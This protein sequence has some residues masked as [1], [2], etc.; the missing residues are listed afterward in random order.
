MNS[1]AFKRVLWI[2][3]AASLATAGCGGDVKKAVLSIRQGANLPCL[4]VRRIKITVFKDEVSGK[5]MEVFGEFYHVD[6]N[7]DLPAG[8]PMDISGLP[9]TN[10][11]S[12]LVEGFDSSEKRRMCLGRMEQVT[13]EQVE[14]GDLGEM[15]LERESVDDGGVPTYPTGTLVVPP[16]PGIADVGKVDSLAFIVNAGTTDSINGRFIADPRASLSSTTLVLSNLLSR[17]PPNSLIIVARYQNVS[18]GQ[19]KNTSAFTIGDMFTEV[20]MSKEPG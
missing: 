13:Q 16:L 4:G 19:W 8:L 18:V 3:L 5:S 11:M 10:K 14:T 9:Y 15:A 6:G 1:A 2:I 20:P 12:I 17:D 7:C